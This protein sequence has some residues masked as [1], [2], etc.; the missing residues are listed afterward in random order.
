M[1]SS[2]RDLPDV[3]EAA[4]RVA[5]EAKNVGVWGR[6]SEREGRGHRP[7]GHRWP[8]PGDRGGHRRLL[9]CRRALTRQALEWAAEIAVA[10][11]C[12]QEVRELMPDPN[13]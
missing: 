2:G 12:A 3:A 8:V 9:R 6:E 13:V 10:C 5:Q 11:R 4:P 7:D 1:T